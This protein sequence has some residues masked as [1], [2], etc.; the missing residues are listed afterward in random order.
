MLGSETVALPGVD[1]GRETGRQQPTGADPAQPERTGSWPDDDAAR[2]GQRFS[3]PV[4]SGAFDGRV[5]GS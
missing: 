1:A 4:A 5:T 2:E 3:W